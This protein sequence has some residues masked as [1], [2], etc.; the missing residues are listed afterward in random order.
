MLR[1]MFQQQSGTALWISAWKQRCYSAHLQIFFSAFF[2]LYHHKA[3]SLSRIIEAFLGMIVT[4]F[5]PNLFW[6]VDPSTI[7]MEDHA[8]Y[9]IQRTLEYGQMNDWRLINHYYGLNRIVS[10][11]KKMRSLDP[12]CLS[13]I[14]TISHTKEEEYRCYHFRQSFQTPWNS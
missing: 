5:S 8:A 11:C 1:N 13:F 3:L 7:S 14:C 6:D 12:V 10:E 4:A 9:I 2:W